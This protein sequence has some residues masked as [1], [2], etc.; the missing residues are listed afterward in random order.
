MVEWKRPRKWSR[1]LVLPLTILVTLSKLLD[2][3]G[4]GRSVLVSLF[5][6]FGGETGCSPTPFPIWGAIGALELAHS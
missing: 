5:V 1:D 6:K 4:G 3:S 2:F